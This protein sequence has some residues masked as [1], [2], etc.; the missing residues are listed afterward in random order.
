MDS[1]QVVLDTGPD[2]SGMALDIHGVLAMLADQLRH[3]IGDTEEF[4][5]RRPDYLQGLSVSV[6]TAREMASYLHG[7]LD[8][9]ETYGRPG[10]QHSAPG[11]EGWGRLSE[12]QQNVVREL[13]QDIAGGEV[14]PLQVATRDSA[15]FA[16][17][18]IEAQTS[19]LSPEECGA[20]LARGGIH[21]SMPMSGPDGDPYA[22][23]ETWTL[24]GLRE[25]VAK[26]RLLDS[27]TGNPHQDAW[28]K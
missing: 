8:S 3:Q 4:E 2:L 14:G 18:R 13:V 9:I 20:E 19:K 1:H 24:K 21:V 10:G 17:A 23:T 6:D 16:L 25:R 11:L 28:Q 27:I 15:R 5:R 22:V 26:Q 7:A 12:A